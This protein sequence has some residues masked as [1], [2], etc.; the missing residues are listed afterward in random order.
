MRV[1]T[2]YPG[3]TATPMQQKV[4]EQEG[5]DYDA[6]AWIDPATVADAI[7]H[8]LDLGPRRDDQR[9]DDPPDLTLSP[10]QAVVA[11]EQARFALAAVAPLR[12]RRIGRR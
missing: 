3:R 5:R 12:L 6:D 9:P 2:V 4:H 10:E 8:V 11:C 1:T 7:L